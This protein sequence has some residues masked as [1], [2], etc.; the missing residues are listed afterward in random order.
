MGEILREEVKNDFPKV[1]SLEFSEKRDKCWFEMENMQ[2]GVKNPEP[3]IFSVKSL[4]IK[5]LKGF[6]DNKQINDED[7]YT[8][9]WGLI[10]KS[11]MKEHTYR[12]KGGI[13]FNI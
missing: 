6:N 13:E 11:C 2:E 10:S 1:K 4:A 7:K 5:T 9:W 12:K 3:E 8:F